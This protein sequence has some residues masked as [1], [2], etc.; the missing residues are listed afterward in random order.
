MPALFDHDPAI[1]HNQPIGATQGT[2]T[3]GNCN[4]CSTP[5]QILKCLLDF[6]FRCGVHRRSR[7]VKNQ[8]ARVDQQS[9]GD[10]NPLTFAPR[11]GL[12]PLANHR[13]VAMRKPQD[14]FVRPRRAGSLDDFGPGGLRRSIGNVFG[15]RSKKQ[16]RLLEDEANIAPVIGQGVPANIDAIDQN[17]SLRDV[18]EATNEINQR[19]LARTAVPHQANHL[20]RRNVQVDAPNDRAVSVTKTDAPN[21]NTSR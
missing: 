16:K 8:D 11:K 5:D 2:E 3:M 1:E 13:V 10:R 14:K 19:A 20:T 4:R 21:L 7:L 18:M 12:P 15:N 9:T 17:G 6:N